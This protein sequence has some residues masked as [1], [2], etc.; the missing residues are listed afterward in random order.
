MAAV[1]LQR[2]W[3]ELGTYAL[4]LLRFE[5]RRLGTTVH[6]GKVR[7]AWADQTRRFAHREP[8][9]GL[10]ELSAQRPPAS[11]GRMEWLL[12]HSHFY[13]LS[14]E[15][16]DADDP[17][18]HLAIEVAAA[19]DVT[20]PAASVDELR[21]RAVRCARMAFDELG[22]DLGRAYAS[23]HFKVRPSMPVA[24]YLAA[25]ADLP[26]LVTLVRDSGDPTVSR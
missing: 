26:D 4:D 25:A 15:A 21:G 20:T 8:W 24:E 12:W 19:Y 6:V 18:P 23:N 3:T 14:V 7:L 9:R 22:A 5:A 1:W 2:T 16:C 10:R 17:S 13:G 11:A